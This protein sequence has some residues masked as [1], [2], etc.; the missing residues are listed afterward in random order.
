MSF[1]SRETDDEHIAKQRQRALA[2]ARKHKVATDGA[3]FVAHSYD[4]KHG[5]QFLIVWPDRVEVV[6]L[7]IQGMLLQRKGAGVESISLSNVT[8]AECLTKSISTELRVH[9]AGNTMAFSTGSQPTAEHLRALISERA[10]TVCKSLQEAGS[11]SVLQQ[12]KQ[13]AELRDAGIVSEEEFALK[14]AELLQRL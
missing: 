3:D 13:L 2:A 9:S 5:D 8:S 1:F 11:A 7:G 10:A 14:K 4:S 12:I 6:S